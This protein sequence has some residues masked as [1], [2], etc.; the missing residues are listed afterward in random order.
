MEFYFVHLKMCINLNIV[1]YKS[2]YTEKLWQMTQSINLNIVE[3]KFASNWKI[4]MWEFC[5]NLNI[6]EYKYTV[7]NN[8]YISFAVLI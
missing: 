6:V 2:I 1:E 5:I 3:Y 7:D 4:L 8:R